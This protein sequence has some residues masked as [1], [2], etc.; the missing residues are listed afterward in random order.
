MEIDANPSRPS[1]LGRLGHVQ[2]RLL[3]RRINHRYTQHL[4]AIPIFSR[5]CFGQFWKI[6]KLTGSVSRANE[7][8]KT[9]NLKNSGLGSNVLKDI[10]NFFPVSDYLIWMIPEEFI[11][12]TRG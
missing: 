2:D 12:N 10:V 9:L 8:S 6:C 7:F 3:D 11:R 5:I 1:R 4:L